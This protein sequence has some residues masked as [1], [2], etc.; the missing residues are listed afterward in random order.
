[1]IPD[2]KYVFGSSVSTTL[3]FS[4]NIARECALFILKT[5]KITS[6]SSSILFIFQEEDEEAYKK[7]FS[8]YIKH[9]ISA[10]SIESMY[11]KAH[12]AIRSDPSAKP[13]PKKDVAK[14]RWNAKKITLEARK[15]RVA[16]AKEKF[17]AQIEAQKE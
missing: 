4:T 14:K 13:K 9:G 5:F 8:R 3:A 15:A 1:M 2:P 7:Q 17:L 10:D 11:K 12:E 16:E 6:N